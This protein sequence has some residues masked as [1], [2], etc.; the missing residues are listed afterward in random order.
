MIAGGELEARA[1]DLDRDRAGSARSTTT[2]AAVGVLRGAGR[3]AVC[4]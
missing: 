1:H 2:T 4:C 3:G